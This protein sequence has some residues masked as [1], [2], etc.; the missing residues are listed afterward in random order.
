MCFISHYSRNEDY[1]FTAFNSCRA[2]NGLFHVNMCFF[3]LN[4]NSLLST[5]SLQPAHIKLELC[6]NMHRSMARLNLMKL[7]MLIFY[8]RVVS[9]TL[10][11][12]VHKN[13][14]LFKKV[15]FCNFYLL[16]IPF[17]A[18]LT[19]STFHLNSFSH[20]L[21]LQC[22][23]IFVAPGALQTAIGDCYHSN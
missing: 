12:Y 11:R 2:T 6:A 13:L 21:F 3:F 1:L 5:F 23:Y 20:Y 22:G 9:Y 4:I 19:S 7:E 10:S 18:I 17:F 16:F 14:K 15:I 8:K